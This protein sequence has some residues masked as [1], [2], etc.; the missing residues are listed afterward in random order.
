MKIQTV[1]LL[2]DNGGNYGQTGPEAGI[3]SSKPSWL[4]LSGSGAITIA[5]EFFIENSNQF[6]GTIGPE[7]TVNITWLQMQIDT[8]EDFPCSIF[9]FKFSI[10]I[11][12]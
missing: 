4:D 9:N 12:A 8:L 1:E 2:P 7:K 10:S 3:H 5:A 6:A 11:M